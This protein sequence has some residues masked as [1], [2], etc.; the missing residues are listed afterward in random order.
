MK[1]ES[2]LTVPRSTPAIT[3]LTYKEVVSTQRVLIPLKILTKTFS[4]KL[5]K[6]RSPNT[7]VV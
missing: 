2:R 1:R 5:R 6:V 3:L 4:C 7:L